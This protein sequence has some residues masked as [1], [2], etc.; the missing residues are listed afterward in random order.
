MERH[1][2]TLVHFANP[3]G[4]G[5]MSKSETR[6]RLNRDSLPHYARIVLQLQRQWLS[7]ALARVSVSWWGIALG[8]RSQFVGSPSFVRAR[9]STIQ[10]GSDGRFLS[11]T[12]S[13][14][15][16][17]NRA[18]MITTLRPGA[19]I[20]IGDRAGFSGVVICAAERVEIG[21]RVMLGANVTIT[22][23]DS[24]PIAYRMRH[25]AIFG[26][27]PKSVET[28][29]ETRPVKIGDDVFV[30]MHSLILK[31][32]TIGSGSVV[33]AGSVVAHDLPEHCIAAGN[34]ARV[35][36]MLEPQEGGAFKNGFEGDVSAAG[37]DV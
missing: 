33:G 29:V 22:D 4:A 5:E 37:Q 34:P 20:R 3:L 13:N 18:C 21:D 12:T 10:V 28:E 19:V 23:T 27:P 14:R 30:G 35:I 24:H 7:T 15:H 8:P 36:R 11:A 31:G 16:G 26:T 25:P 2:A 9:G 6:S 17:I 32:V 1:L